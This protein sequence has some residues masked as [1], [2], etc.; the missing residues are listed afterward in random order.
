M[1][2]TYNLVFNESLVASETG[3]SLSLVLSTYSKSLKSDFFK[4]ILV[5]VTPLTTCTLVGFTNSTQ[6]ALL[7]AGK[8][9]KT[10][11]L[12]ESNLTTILPTNLSVAMPVPVVNANISDWL[13]TT[14]TDENEIAGI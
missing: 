5:P 11:F 1:S 14:S 13:L 10:K 12:L 4:T 8:F 7:L 9:A 2:V 6:L 3:L